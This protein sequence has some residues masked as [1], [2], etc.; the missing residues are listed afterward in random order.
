ML[1]TLT[2]FNSS[3]AIVAYLSNNPGEM[4][5]ILS[6]RQKQEAMQG[7][8]YSDTL[9]FSIPASHD[10]AQYCVQGGFVGFTDPD[11]YFQLYQIVDAQKDIGGA[12][13]LYC[14]CEHA[15]YEL[16]SEPI[17]DERPEN[18]MAGQAVAQLLTGTRWELGTADDLG[19]NT[20]RVYYSSVLKGLNQVAEKWGGELRF[21]LH[22]TGGVID[23]RYVDIL[24]RR[25]NDTGKRFER[26]KD[27]VSVKQ[28]INRQELCTAVYPRGRGEEVSTDENGINYGRRLTIAD[29]IWTT[30]GD[31]ANKP[32][33]QEWVGDDAA[34]AA[35]GAAGGTR[36]IFGYINFDDC[37][38]E[39]ELIQ[40][41]W[42]YL[43]TVNAPRV[44]YDI[45]T[46]Q[47]EGLTG[48]GHEA[49]RLG[50]GVYIINTSVS[51]VIQGE[52]RVISI[53]RNLLNLADCRVVLGNYIPAV[54]D[55]LIAMRDY[56]AS[57]RDRAGVFDR[58]NA[59]QKV[60]GAGG[61]IEL[62]LDLLKVQLASTISGVST[63]ANGNIISETPDKTKATKIGAG[64][65]ALA[66]SI[67]SGEYD[68]RTFLTGDGAVADL[69]VVGAMLADRVRAGLL[70][71]ETGTTWIDMDDGTFNFANMIA[72]DGTTLTLNPE[73]VRVAVGQ[74]GGQN[75]VKNSTGVFALSNWDAYPPSGGWVET[76]G[77]NNDDC[78]K[79]V[80]STSGYSD[81]WS[82]E[83]AVVEGEKYTIS[84]EADNE[85]G[86]DAQLHVVST[87]TG[88]AITIHTI[89]AGRNVVTVTI[90][91]GIT[92]IQLVFRKLATV[93]GVS[94]LYVW[95]IMGQNGEVATAWAPHPNEV[96]SSSFEMIDAYIKM[97][98]KQILMEMLDDAGI[99]RFSIDSTDKGLRAKDADGI[100]RVLLN[101]LGTH[102]YGT[103]DGHALEALLSGADLRNFYD[104]KSASLFRFDGMYLYDYW[105]ASPTAQFN[106]LDGQ[107]GSEHGIWCRFF[108]SFDFMNFGNESVDNVFQIRKSAD[109]S[110]ELANF[111]GNI[112][113][114]G[115]N[116]KNLGRIDAPNT[117]GITQGNRADIAKLYANVGNAQYLDI[118]ANREWNGSDWNSASWM[119]CRIIDVTR[120]GFIQF[121]GGDVYL[122]DGSNYAMHTDGTGIYVYEN[123]SAHS[124]TD[125]TPYFD[126]D[127]LSELLQIRGK[128]G[129]ID[130]GTMPKF[131][132]YPVRR[133]V[134]EKRMV[135]KT[136]QKMQR[137]T[138]PVESEE[139]RLVEGKYTLIKTTIP[140]E[141][142]EPVFETVE[143]YDEQGKRIYETVPDKDGKSSIQQPAT[144]QLPVM[145]EYE[146]IEQ[147]QVGEEDVIERNIGNGLSMCIRGEQQLAEICA[148][149]QKQIDELKTLIQQLQPGVKI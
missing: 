29:V 83:F 51:P 22:L 5:V 91:S 112:H 59:F 48:Y 106:F 99:T 133:P 44:T 90:T 21:R 46:V 34:K 148:G 127:A 98:S 32:A 135:T 107:L 74:I 132:Q 87:A 56:Q 84:F 37:T 12:D 66:N 23:H 123:C 93:S 121:Y 119:I 129:E 134:H 18:D 27:L 89:T 55:D 16:M 38:D 78:F 3:E 15:F 86:S 33:G 72:F 71:A 69:I 103:I 122:G 24:A 54:D 36:H 149:L 8:G 40:L 79:I 110:N 63:D 17:E 57:F 109:S 138:R 126:G 88:T 14:V 80:S 111:W 43:Q 136:R 117:L 124:Y 125:R 94:A 97:R 45:T 10:D 58:A 102:T 82:S 105:N 130:H 28:T 128:D 104:G 147:V 6:C 70:A 20:V 19:T 95:F 131:M 7:G 1:D 50:D 75:L 142:D 92:G 25:G 85:V 113:M 146:E 35:Y 47:L 26:G 73:A 52:A 2:V 4:P 115:K 62:L 68:W 77:R 137:V 60:S 108:N 81:I 13:I 30:P 101:Y 53:D 145:E 118:Y 120:M 64:I 100:T 76:G 139:V 116:I 96:K 41:G 141:V 31:P 144:R 9:E 67:L 140:E 11:G 49:V 114:H 143:I 42:D 61:T 39:E 65:V